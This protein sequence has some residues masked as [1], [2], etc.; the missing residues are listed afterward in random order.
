MAATPKQVQ[1][2][3]E[4][5]ERKQFPDNTD[6]PALTA[7]FANLTRKNASEWIDR[8]LALPNLPDADD[9]GENVAAPF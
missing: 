3:G 1:L 5:T 9:D 6:L 2:F 8:A 4:L 7:K